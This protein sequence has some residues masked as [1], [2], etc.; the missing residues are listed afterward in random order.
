MFN[1][2]Y[3]DKPQWI[4]LFEKPYDLEVPENPD[5]REIGRRILDDHGFK[6]SYG[7]W[8]N[9][10]QRISVNTFSFWG[11]TR[12]FYYIEDKRIVAEDKIFRWD[13][14][15]TKFH[16]IGGYQ[17]ERLLHDG[18]AFTIDLVCFSMVIWVL[19]GIYMWWQNKS[20][21]LWG[22]VALGSGF[23]TFIFISY[24]DVKSQTA[25][26]VIRNQVITDFFQRMSDYLLF[27]SLSQYFTLPGRRTIRK[28]MK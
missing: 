1:E 24:C 9:G 23:L 17:Q 19:S 27:F 26:L 15:L 14:F 12:F 8:W 4:E 22:S 16:W 11:T 10:N 20:T 6:G 28:P 3:K 18:W 25:Y 2:Y 5:M 21:R 7:A 13:H